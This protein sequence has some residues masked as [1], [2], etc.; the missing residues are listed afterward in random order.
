[1][2]VPV[3]PLHT[4]PGAQ[5]SVVSQTPWHTPPTHRRPPGHGLLPPH[6]DVPG[7][8]SH[9]PR[10]PQIYP[11]GQGTVASHPT[12]QRPLTQTRDAPHSELYS[13]GDRQTPSRHASPSSH[14]SPV[15]HGHSAVDGSQVGVTSAS[16]P[17]PPAP[18]VAAVPPAPAMP[19]VP[20]VPPVPAAVPPDPGAA[21][22]Q[23]YASHM[24][25][26]SSSQTIS[27]LLLPQ[28][29]SP[30]PQPAPGRLT[31]RRTKARGSPP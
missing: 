27:S 22:R 23:P 31:G 7:S 4:S 12:T 9:V 19:D 18:P 6:P 11:S 2:H 10:L 24:R 21:G 13:H 14:V 5:S 26:P 30:T 20:A 17:A 28:P 29:H 25:Q 1:M 16:A 15:P 8:T 3:A